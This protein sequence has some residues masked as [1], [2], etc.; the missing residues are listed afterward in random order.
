MKLKAFGVSHGYCPDLS[1]IRGMPL[2]T[3]YLDDKKLTNLAVLAGAPI[4]DLSLGGCTELR[5]ISA[6]RKMPLKI[7]NLEL[8]TK[9]RDFTP[10]LECPTLERVALPLGVKEIEVLRRHPAI[11]A[12]TYDSYDLGYI[13]AAD[14]WF[15]YDAQRDPKMNERIAQIRAAIHDDRAS[16]TATWGLRLNLANIAGLDLNLIRQLPIDFLS[17]CYTKITNLAP[18]R[19]NV[20]GSG[21][22]A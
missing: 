5:D 19:G 14:F 3:V 21:M 16:V 22:S 11:K 9:L 7:L 6:L 13:P 8:C 17:L 4:T 18:L 1:V 12:L 10:L 15:D 2:S 20:G